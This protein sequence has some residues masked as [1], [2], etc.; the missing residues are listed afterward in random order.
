MRLIWMAAAKTLHKA[1]LL[2]DGRA[3]ELIAVMDTEKRAEAETPKAVAAAID[4]EQA[5]RPQLL[6]SEDPEET[7]LDLIMLI[8]LPPSSPR[9]PW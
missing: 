9:P 2:H 3:D 4:A 7:M 6:D 8:L 1:E 5:A